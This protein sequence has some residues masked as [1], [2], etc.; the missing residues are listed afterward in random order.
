[1]GTSQQGILSPSPGLPKPPM[2]AGAASI[3]HQVPNPYAPNPTLGGFGMGT[4]GIQL[5]E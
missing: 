1:M 3:P 5:Q 4:I 2:S